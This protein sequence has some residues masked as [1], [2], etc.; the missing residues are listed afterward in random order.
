[1]AL[2]SCGEGEGGGEGRFSWTVATVFHAPPRLRAFFISTWFMNALGD[3]G[4]GLKSGTSTSSFVD[5]SQELASWTMGDRAP[6]E[7]SMEYPRGN[8][9]KEV[10]LFSGRIDEESTKDGGSFASEEFT[11]FIGCPTDERRCLA[12]ETTMALD[13]SWSLSWLEMGP[14]ADL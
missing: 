13:M 12:G 3:S 5:G 14:S 6:L 1:M 8:F 2:G 4:L 7:P 11:G 9:A 10:T